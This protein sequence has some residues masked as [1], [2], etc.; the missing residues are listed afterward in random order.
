MLE[1]FVEWLRW[2][3]QIQYLVSGSTEKFG[4]ET[5]RPDISIRDFG[6]HWGSKVYNI[7]N[8]FGGCKCSGH[9]FLGKGGLLQPGSG[10]EEAVAIPNGESGGQSPIEKDGIFFAEGGRGHFESCSVSQHTHDWHT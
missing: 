2:I 7:S 8:C 10:L 5:A 9:V 6:S 1:F 3:D 4:F